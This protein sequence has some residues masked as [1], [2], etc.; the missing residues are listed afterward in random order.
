MSF[1]LK[2]PK[3]RGKFPWKP[4][5]DMPEECPLCGAFVG[6]T[7]ADD[8]VVMPFIRKKSAS[9]DKVYRDIEAGS[10]QR[11][12]M[13]AEQLGVPEAEMSGIKI[14]NLS[15]RR[16]TEV[17]AIPVSN[18]VT[19]FMQ[20]HNMQPFQG[21]NGVDYSGAVQSGSFPN[22][23]AKM[24]TAIQNKHAE[25]S[26]GSAVSDRPAVE[27]TVPGYRRRG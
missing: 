12:K 18:P 22:M 16:D 7:R 13:A 27:T 15:D 6:N 5:N 14:N 8:D 3:C 25:I 4:T 19:Q 17:A 11:A 23:G 2:C 26:G 24:R 20:Q 9:I 21:G 1:S 10:E